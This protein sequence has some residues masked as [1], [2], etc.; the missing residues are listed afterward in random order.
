MWGAKYVIS[1]EA[2]DLN[3]PT[4]DSFTTASNVPV[5]CD[6]VIGSASARQQQQ[7]QRAAGCRIERSLM[8]SRLLRGFRPACGIPVVGQ[9]LVLAR[10][11]VYRLRN[12]MSHAT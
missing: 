5:E 1:I 4:C 10:D 6:D 3:I 11:N 7:Q 12:V 8:D 2:P 9:H